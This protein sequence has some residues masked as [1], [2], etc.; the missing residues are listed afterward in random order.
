ME[1]LRPFEDESSMMRGIAS[2]LYLFYLDVQFHDQYQNCLSVSGENQEDERVIRNNSAVITNLRMTDDGIEF[3]VGSLE[4]NIAGGALRWI[5][6]HSEMAALPPEEPRVTKNFDQILY[7]QEDL[8][9]L[10]IGRLGPIAHDRVKLLA[11]A[12]KLIAE[13]KISNPIFVAN[14]DWGDGVQPEE[15]TLSGASLGAIIR[16]TS[17]C[18]N[19]PQIYLLDGDKYST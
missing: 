17:D 2:F 13:N 10:S 4:F 1:T 6:S 12:E 5:K 9:K 16:G 7:T 8:D 14:P 15:I 19:T 11:I 3:S 18:T